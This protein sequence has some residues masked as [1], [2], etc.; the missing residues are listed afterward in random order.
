[1]LAIDR[2]YPNWNSLRIHESSPVN[3]GT[4]LRL[5]KECSQYIP[6]QYFL[7]KDSCEYVDGVLSE[8]LESLSF[9]DNSI[10][11]HITQDVMEHVLNPEKAFKEIARTLKPGGAHIFTVPLVN[12]ND[13]SERCAVLADDGTIRH[14]RLP[15]EYHG[16]PLSNEG[17]LVTTRWGYDITRHIFD[18]C[19]LFTEIIFIDALEFGIRADLI[20]VLLTRKELLKPSRF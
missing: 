10:D 14:L 19:G 4:S 2:F 11:I 15:P 16:N 18:A 3:R 12:K 9:P 13:K 1:M 17:S 6:S 8:N 5:Q 20:E 7:D